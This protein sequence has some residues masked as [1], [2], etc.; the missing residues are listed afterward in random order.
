METLEKM[1][2]VAEIVEKSRA[3]L[4][5]DWRPLL[6]TAHGQQHEIVCLVRR[7]Q[8]L[9]AKAALG[10][11]RGPVLGACS[12][13]PGKMTV[14]KANELARYWAKAVDAKFP[15]LDVSQVTGLSKFQTMVIA[16]RHDIFIVAKAAESVSL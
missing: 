15:S 14:E 1:P 2:F 3:Q 6:S 9:M 16:D 13:V 4:Q 7:F 5:S 10:K 8:V 12:I 11:K